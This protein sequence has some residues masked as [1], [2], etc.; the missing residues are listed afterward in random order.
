MTL[1]TVIP[2]GYEPDYR[3]ADI[4]RHDGGQFFGCTAAER[5][6]GDWR[7]TVAL[8]LFDQD[9]N[10]LRTEFRPDTAPGDA[11]TVLA[12]LIGQLSGVS[13]GDIGIR[14]FEITAHGRKW[15][16]LDKSDDVGE[17]A[18][19]VPQGLAFYPPWNGEY[20]T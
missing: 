5:V 11:P 10:H 1:P 12:T 4:G 8:H 9:G 20:D 14:L 13:Y 2:V 6:G 7:I 19:L 3:T 16:L 18:E 17:R 15:G